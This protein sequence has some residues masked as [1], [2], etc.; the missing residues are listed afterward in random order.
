MPV[1]GS[2][3]PWRLVQARRHEI[4]WESFGRPKSVVQGIPRCPFSEKWC[5]P[6]V[7]RLFGW[8]PNIWLD[9]E[10]DTFWTLFGPLFDTENREIRHKSRKRV[11]K[12]Q[13]FFDEKQ[14]NK[15]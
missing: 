2:L 13:H 6:E 1:L 14:G 10:N 7:A 15:A 4:V 3:S 12:N 9:L 5:R 11:S 8:R